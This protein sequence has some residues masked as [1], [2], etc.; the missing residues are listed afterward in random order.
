MYYPL[1]DEC[2]AHKLFYKCII[3]YALCNNKILLIKV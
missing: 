1:S 3:E 2:D